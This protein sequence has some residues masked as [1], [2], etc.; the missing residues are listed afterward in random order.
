MHL[1]LED[2][3]DLEWALRHSD[4][5]KSLRICA[6]LLR[7][8]RPEGLIEALGRFPDLEMIRVADDYLRTEAERSDCETSVRTM[9]PD[10]DFRWTYDL[11]I[12]GRHGR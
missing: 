10:L 8:I 12:D 9:F 3:E 2:T 4:G 1:I 6:V 11:R 5:V 7:S